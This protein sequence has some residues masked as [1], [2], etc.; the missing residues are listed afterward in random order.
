MRYSALALLLLR[1]LLGGIFIWAALGKIWDPRH[2][3]QDIDHYRIL[4]Y[5]LVPLLAIVLPWLE[6]LCG[7][8]LVAGKWPHSS[9]LILV[10]LNFIF[11]VAIA[12]AM[13]RG[14]DI[15]CGCFTVAGE[16]SRVG[17]QRLLEDVFFLLMAL[18]VALLSAIRRDAQHKD[19]PAASA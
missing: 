18:L 3:S 12:S 11:I 7:L 8:A 13:A 5:A 17:W 2:F 14:L 9:A 1:L 4:P 15:D 10:A 19:L 16:A 6:L